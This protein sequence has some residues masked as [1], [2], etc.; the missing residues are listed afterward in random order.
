MTHRD[1]RITFEYTITYA[2]T[3]V[4]LL[5]AVST[6]YA[7]LYLSHYWHYENERPVVCL[8]LVLKLTTFEIEKYVYLIRIDFSTNQK[9]KLDFDVFKL[10]SYRLSKNSNRSVL[11]VFYPQNMKYSC[12][13][14]EKLQG[15][16]KLKYFFS[17]SHGRIQY[18]MCVVVLL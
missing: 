18:R 5:Y 8:N 6:T 16:L 17:K 12:Y 3:V 9:L 2:V 4:Y 10:I 14:A 11:K 15:V 1:F 13:Y 7:N